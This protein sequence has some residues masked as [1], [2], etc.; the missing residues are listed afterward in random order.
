MLV[1]QREMEP[2]ATLATAAEVGIGIA[3]FSSI[4][5]AIAARPAGGLARTSWLQL[6]LLLQSSFAVV[7]AAYLPMVLAATSLNE[8][9]IWFAASSA[10]ATWLIFAIAMALR[11]RGP[12]RFNTV[13]GA[14]VA[15]LT[16]ASL[17]FHLYNVLVAVASWPY[18]AALACGL[19]VAFSQFVSLV[20]DL[21]IA[22]ERTA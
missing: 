7:L 11:E 17:A 2:Q 13:N 14:L 3:G 21:Y 1:R 6:R 16:L 22:P 18:L 19:S 5:A 9:A 8:S 12:R 10:Y 4:A 15:T 20:R